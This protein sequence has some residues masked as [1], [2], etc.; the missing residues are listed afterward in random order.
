[1]FEYKKCERYAA[2]YLS[3]FKGEN[4]KNKLLK[5][6]A[7]MLSVSTIA[8][9]NFPSLAYEVD[10]D[11]NS[12][13]EVEYQNTNDDY[14]DNSSLV[15]AEI[16]S[17]YKV[18][19]P[20]VV[21]LSGNTKDAKYF[22]KVEGDVAGYETVRVE[23]EKSFNLYAKNKDA[24]VANINQD[25]VIW[26][27]ADFDTDAAGYINA[28][29]ITAG[30]WTGTFNFNLNLE[31]V[32]GDFSIPSN[33]NNDYKL[34]ISKISKIPGLY[35]DNGKLIISYIS[36]NRKYNVS[37]NSVESPSSENWLSDIINTCYKK[38]A[39]VS[40]PD[41]I[42]QIENNALNNTNIKYTTIPESVT[43]IG[44]NVFPDTTISVNLPKSVVYYGNN[45][46]V[47]GITYTSNKNTNNKSRQVITKT[48]NLENADSAKITLIKGSRYKI[49]A[50]YNFKDDVTGESTITSD[51]PEIVEYL[52]VYYLDAL[53]KGTCILSGTYNAATSK[54]HASITVQVIDTHTH[55]SNI[56]KK[57]NVINASCT[58]DGSYDEVKYCSECGEEIS[59][60]TKT[61]PAT[62]HSWTSWQILREATTE[63]KGLREKTCI[64]CG[65]IV[66]NEFSHAGLYD[67]NENQ[68]MSWDELIENGD[69]SVNNGV[70]KANNKALSGKLIISNSVTS[71]SVNAFRDHNSLTSITIPNSVTSIGEYAFYNC[72]S[73]ASITIP[74]SVTSIGGY[75]FYKCPS[76]TSVT[77]P[78]SVTSIGYNAFRE[79]KSLTSVTIP[80]SV[81]D[82]GEGAFYGTAIEEIII[83]DSVTK[84]KSGTFTACISLKKVTLPDTI[85]EIGFAAFN[86]DTAI[87]ELII[88]DSVTSIGS[89]AFGNVPHIYYN[90]TATGKPWGAKAIN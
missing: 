51:S 30:S 10:E 34:I 86:T 67:E 71:I 60:T 57:E 32:P 45:A 49:E 26:R 42:T 48:I 41:T 76:L 24:V 11:K 58:K 85:T 56:T 69:I 84:I 13:E 23:P 66:R 47:D 55:N 2:A 7:M 87:E 40:L 36:L 80:N 27:L 63:S 72:K 75:A 6:M 44:D 68:I 31:S 39:F 17:Q 77:I 14:F 78:D 81:T 73:L 62:G 54:K 22:V 4:M 43:T 18:T 82:L 9:T 53:E 64:T 50:L 90:G 79:C 21:V 28:E 59:R 20:K 29:D 65:E 8:S 70:L 37:L 35:D 88:P 19:I 46:N 12:I 33:F 16:G 83:P 61:V 52:P 74:D 89:L 25:K 3:Y 15:F 38:T 5:M 1:M